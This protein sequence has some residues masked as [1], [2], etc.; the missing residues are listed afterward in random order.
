MWYCLHLNC[1]IV[2]V[3][4]VVI[5]IVIINLLLMKKGLQMV[6]FAMLYFKF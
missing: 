6:F 4:I 3:V 1:F 2:V 5:I